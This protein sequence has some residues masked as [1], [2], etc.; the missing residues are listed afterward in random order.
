V[1]VR[2][3]AGKFRG[4]KIKTPRGSGTRPPLARIKKSLF[5]I[6]APRLDG[7]RVLDL[8]AGSG[9]FGLEALS[10]GAAEA[11]LVESSPPAAAVIEQNIRDLGVKPDT[12]LLRRSAE[13][14]LE[15]LVLG[16]DEFDVAFIDPPFKDDRVQELLDRTGSLIAPGGVAVVRVPRFRR[17][18]DS[19]GGLALARTEIYGAS[20]VGFYHPSEE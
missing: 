8:F 14:S 3:I 11:V 13:P 7:A 18:P 5:D 17:L 1:S 9:S 6:L 12:R 15:A 4:R 2:I 19:G 16:G 10:R 20:K